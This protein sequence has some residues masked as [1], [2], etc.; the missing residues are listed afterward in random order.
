MLRS[1]RFSAAKFWDMTRSGS[2][3]LG[4]TRESR[5]PSGWLR[6]LADYSKQQVLLQLGVSVIWFGGF[7]ELPALLERA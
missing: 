6:Q 5:A 2:S 4:H 7:H 3:G 1:R